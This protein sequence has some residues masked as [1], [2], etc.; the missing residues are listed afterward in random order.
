[1]TNPY[2][3]SPWLF[4]KEKSFGSGRSGG[5]TNVALIS[6]ILR[7]TGR[8]CSLSKHSSNISF[9]GGARIDE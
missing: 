9:L 4:W 1:M 6:A 2:S 8:T 3:V 7:A 5:G